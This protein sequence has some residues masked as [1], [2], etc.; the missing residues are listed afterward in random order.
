MSI[1]VKWSISMIHAAS[2]AIQLESKIMIVS[3]TTGMHWTQ[4]QSA[5]GKQITHLV[6]QLQRRNLI[7]L[8]MDFI[9]LNRIMVKHSLYSYFMILQ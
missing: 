6:K 7:A 3:Y 9:D 4:M 5:F 8:P 2:K 1:E